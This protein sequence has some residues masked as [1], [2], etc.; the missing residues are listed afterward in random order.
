MFKDRTRCRDTMQMPRSHEIRQIEALRALRR[1]HAMACKEACS[2][3]ALSVLML[4]PIVR[5]WGL[6]RAS[7]LTARLRVR[8]VH[9]W[10]ISGSDGG[11]AVFTLC[12][13]LYSLAPAFGR[14]LYRRV[15][16]RTAV[17]LPETGARAFPF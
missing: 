7:A 5:F 13:L 3:F 14:P 15:C 16:T 9:M 4:L 12:T 11:A 8:R 2:L 10:R 1:R 17:R 6:F